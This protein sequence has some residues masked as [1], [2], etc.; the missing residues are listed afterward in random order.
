MGAILGCPRA[1]P[2]AGRS[3]PALARKP[4]STQKPSKMLMT[5]FKN[6]YS[7]FQPKPKDPK[8]KDPQP[9]DPKPKDPKPKDPRGREK[10]AFCHTGSAM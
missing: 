1:S 6:R 8:P 4:S 9:K 10:S 2:G 7:Q 5:S 3:L